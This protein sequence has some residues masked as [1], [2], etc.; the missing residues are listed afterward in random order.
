VRA[1]DFVRLRNQYRTWS[2]EDL[3]RIVAR[4]DDYRPEAVQVVG[5][6]LAD[7]DQAEVARLTI[8]VQRERQ[9]P[10]RGL[11]GTILDPPYRE[12]ALAVFGAWLAFMLGLSIDGTV[13]GIISFG[14]VGAVGVV[15]ATLGFAA[16]SRCRLLPQ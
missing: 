14:F 5:E 12:A 4:R 7:R 6:L 2:T 13:R 9:E 10:T 11:L 1:A 3:V 16:T 15:L 8:A